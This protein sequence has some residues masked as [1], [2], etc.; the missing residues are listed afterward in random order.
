MKKQIL[1]AVLALFLTVS[2]CNAVSAASVNNSTTQLAVDNNS[3]ASSGYSAPV[4]QKSAVK[5]VS[6]SAVGGDVYVSKTG[7]DKTGDGSKANPYA[8]I[9]KALEM[10]SS[11]GNI[12]IL[13]GTYNEAGLTIDKNVHILG[14]S[15]VNT[16]IDAQG[17]GNIFTINQGVNVLIQNLTLTHGSIQGS[18]G[19]IYNGGNL[20]LKDCI[21]KENSIFGNGGA[22]YNVGTLTLSSATF[23]GNIADKGGAV[24]NTGTLKVSGSTFT[25]NS[26]LGFEG[27]AVYNEGNLTVTNS[28]FAANDAES[29]SA[30][31]NVGTMAVSGCKFNDNVAGKA[32]AGAVNNNGTATLSGC[33]FTG[34]FAG[35]AGAV[36]N[37][38]KLT[39]KNCTFTNNTANEN[40][41]A[42]YNIGTLTLNNSNFNNNTAYVGGAVEN[43]IENNH[44]SS[45]NATGCTFTGNIAHS[46]GAIDNKSTMTLT[47][48]TFT[49]N[50][51]SFACG[52]IANDE[53]STMTLKDC[54]F[55]NNTAN[56][57]ESVGAGAIGNVGTMILSGCTFIDNNATRGG[58]ILNMES[59]LTLS[60]CT[61]IC[62]TATYFGGAIANSDGDIT[63]HFNR[64]INN[65][66]VAGSAIFND[67][68]GEETTGSVDATYNWWGSNKDPS[69]EFN[70]PVAY[71]PWLVL[72]INSSSD[73][74]VPGGK[75]T[76]TA[77]LQHDSNGVYHNPSEGHLM[78]GTA[79]IFSADNGSLNP[80][81]AELVNGSAVTSFTAKTVCLANVSAT[82]DNETV[83]TKIAVNK[84]KTSLTVVNVT[85]V[86][87]K[88]VSVTAVL[89][90]ENGNLL[91]GKT[92]A[93]AINGVTFTA[94]T[95]ASG[96]AVFNYTPLKEGVY[97]VNASFAGNDDYQGSDAVGVLTVTSSKPVKPD[98]GSGDNSS[99]AAGGINKVHAVDVIGM[100]KTGLPLNYLLLAILAVFGGLVPRRKN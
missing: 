38:G 12:H 2:A 50:I 69:S 89:K 55:I 83:A 20:T 57:S 6:A 24:Y 67:E 13:K 51:A 66:A 74:T 27:G 81:A 35:N 96:V 53:E 58:A 91:A 84:S 37:K 14:E 98:S 80:I 63:A 90:D 39:L 94:V 16:I 8:T 85:S 76:V 44:K 45:L 60:G 28:T 34:N 86:A 59:T 31:L 21:F 61:F 71:G 87:G 30:V 25:D 100:Q 73:K 33:T 43:T 65:S 97:S 41:G 47:S 48:C 10:V 46:E 26:A 99:S 7:D 15:Q 72:T 49:G 95:N 78:D 29:G 56:N 22:I 64:F 54:T 75:V 17:Q 40:G 36:Y 79:V 23:N 92:V 18:G 9:S 68:T 88:V 32:G 52:A 5:T 4:A 1:L 62:N 11:G 19:A 70:G 77:D 93:F 42:I 82:F 3:T